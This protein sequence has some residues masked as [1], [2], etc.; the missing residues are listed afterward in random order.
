[1]KNNRLNKS[2]ISN[3]FDIERVSV[4]N[5]EDGVAHNSLCCNQFPMSTTNLEYKRN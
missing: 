3:S 2:F 1:M 5:L 4:H